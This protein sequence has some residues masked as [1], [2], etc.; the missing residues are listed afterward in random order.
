V[1]GYT[2]G[3][4]RAALAVLFAA[5][6]AACANG[7]GGQ[8]APPTTSGARE[9]RTT[10]A[11]ASSTTL[12]ADLAAQ[13]CQGTAPPATYD[14][15]VV[16]MLENRTW[17][18][19][20]GAGFGSMPYLAGLARHCAFYDDWTETN[21]AQGSLTQYIGLTSG[22]DN[23]RTVN[24]CSPSATCSS[25]D[26]NI[27]RQ[28]RESGGTARDYVEGATAPCSAAGNAP[29]HVPALYYRG[30]YQDASGT[31]SDGD[32][33]SS[34]VRPLTELD[35]AHL[36]TF[37]MVS[38]TLCHDGHDCPNATVDQWLGGFVQPIL[39]GADYRT[40][41]TAVLVLWDED[42]PVPNLL[43]APGARPGPRPGNGS[44]AAA[45][46]TV[47]RMLGLPVLAQ[48]QLVGVGDLRAT[49]GL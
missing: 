26:D 41:R 38:P 3:M 23:P 4:H 49:S 5:V 28:V 13:P 48:G 10:A 11:P 14:H 43:I 16:V 47:E 40:G 20:G 30:T 39:D 22:V 44:H 19:V 24:D 46:A 17:S 45:L 18:K 37:A 35:P 42:H 32:F 33:C 6:V 27:F 21:Q 12:P 1:V 8:A 31:H 9:P 36:P 29:K 2:G 7:G 34:E 25:A 15:V